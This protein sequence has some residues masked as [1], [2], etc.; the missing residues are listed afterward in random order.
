MI[1]AVLFDFDGVV[2]DSEPV[3]YKTFMQFTKPLGIEVD[4]KRWYSEFAG[5]GSKNIFTVLLGEAGITDEKT[6]DEYVDKRKRV[7]GELIKKGEVK[8]KEG[9]ENFLK[10]LRRNGIKTGIVSGGHKENI[11][12]ALSVL[13][14]EKYFDMVVGSR[15]YKRRKPHPD[16]FTTAAEN[17]GVNPEE[18]LAIEDSVSG[19][20]A[21]RD[22]GMKIIIVESPAIESINKSEIEAVVKDFTEFPLEILSC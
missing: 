3:H 12:T 13:G 4:E 10:L 20:R 17:L 11:F 18:C 6:I 9:I 5:T 15:D 16:A 2:V 1:K 19:F 8:M 7:Y 14:L 22:A 21:A